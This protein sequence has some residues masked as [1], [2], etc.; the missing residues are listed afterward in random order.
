MTRA[1]ACT[2]SPARQSNWSYRRRCIGSNGT[3]AVR[4]K[5]ARSLLALCELGLSRLTK[6]YSPC[7]APFS[8]EGSALLR[9]HTVRADHRG[10]A[11]DL[12]LIDRGLRADARQG[13][14]NRRCF[15]QPSPLRQ[16]P[17]FKLLACCFSQLDIHHHHTLS[18]LLGR[19]V[20]RAAGVCAFAILSR[21][22]TAFPGESPSRFT[23][24]T[25]VS[26]ATRPLGSKSSVGE[27]L[28]G[29]RRCKSPPTSTRAS[30]AQCCASKQSSLQHRFT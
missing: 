22:L 29:H 27:I 25:S 24:F 18:T 19:L 3:I 12:L 26:A 14:Q 20:S 7:T 17:A 4:M 13:Q 6:L 21:C 5:H 8:N 23:L 1:R 30:G 9:G 10:L 11:Q 28:A 15:H 2:T 16:L